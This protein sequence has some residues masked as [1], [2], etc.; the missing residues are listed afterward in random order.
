MSS[1]TKPTFIAACLISLSGCID[2]LD[3]NGSP[4]PC[5]DGWVCCE[6]QDVCVPTVERVIAGIRQVLA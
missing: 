2:N 5:A 1:H 3:T 4:C 6:G